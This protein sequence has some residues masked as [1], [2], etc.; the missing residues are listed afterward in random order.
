MV[1]FLSYDKISKQYNLK[2]YGLCDTDKRK[3]LVEKGILEAQVNNQGTFYSVSSIEKYLKKVDEYRKDYFPLMEFIK[4]FTGKKSAVSEYYYYKK[5]KTFSEKTC[6]KLIELDIPITK[7]E[8]YLIKKSSF[9][10]FKNKYLS[11]PQLLKKL[12]KINCYTP[13]LDGLTQYL[14]NHNVEV[15]T[16]INKHKYK[17]VRKRDVEFLLSSIQLKDVQKELNLPKLEYLYTVL[18]QYNIDIFRGFNNISHIEKRD[19]DFLSNL[20]TKLY[21][22]LQLNY[23]TYDEI[24]NL[25]NDINSKTHNF[26]F[27]IKKIPIL[28]RV[29]KYK[30]KTNVY[31]KA[32]V[33]K[34]IEK[35]K[36]EK[37]ASQLCDFAKDSLDYYQL[38]L[39]LLKI[40]NTFFH[41]NIELTKEIWFQY[42][43]FIIQNLNGAHHSN[44]ARITNFRYTTKFLVEFLS[45]KEIYEFKEKQLNIGIFNEN[46]PYQ[47][48]AEIYRF[49][50]K[51]NES[52]EQRGIKIFDLNK[53]SFQSQTFKKRLENE[54][55]SVEE[56]LGL[57]SFTSDYKK[58]KELAIKDLR[59]GISNPNN[60]KKYDSIWLYVLI[61]LN[62]GWRKS[63]VL[64]FPR[65]KDYI[66]SKFNITSID[67][68]ENLQLTYKEA[69]YII[70]SYQIQWYEHNKTKYKATFYCSSLLTIP[71]AYA[72]LICEWRCRVLHTTDEKYLINFYNKRQEIS[73]TGHAAFFYDFSKD[74]KFESRKLNRTVLTLTSSVIKQT[75]N[76]NHKNI[77]DPIKVAGHLRG[78]SFTDTTNKYMK[79]PQE[80]LDFITEQLFDIGYFGF[81]YDY[82]SNTLIGNKSISRENHTKKLQEIKILLGDVVKLENLSIYLK[83]LTQ[84]RDFSY[85]YLNS[86]SKEELENKLKLIKIGLL[87]SNEE[88]YQCLFA[89]CIAN[90]IDCN[91]CPFSIPHFYS[92]TT[93]A[94]RIKRT[95]KTYKT[96]IA[97]KNVPKGEFTKLYNSLIN[98]YIN[99][100]EAEKKFGTEII[101]MFVDDI[102]SNFIGELNLLPD[103]EGF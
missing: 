26:K 28:A 93:I 7:E 88:N 87:S 39:D 103:P 13:T 9:Y 76:S 40:D 44:I 47:Y 4:I 19:F 43:K 8:K 55:Y 54:I 31:K 42:V 2:N 23:Y 50:K 30:N 100:L 95:I 57:I 80:H 97:K 27:T 72:I 48:R 63:D 38:Y 21:N 69:E 82:L 73:K 68:L 10:R 81:I 41:E 25:L 24:V 34:F 12:K 29:K 32:E 56:Y 46:V 67:S 65:P 11:M 33:D 53:I 64:K 90:N 14:K 62:N 92:L 60:Y 79:I 51:F 6:L 18:R 1:K 52:L 77:S 86:L 59:E 74:F 36:K 84:Q 45:E 16:F 49:L 102:K 3:L 89:S 22:E 91:R 96:L 75:F 20:Q 83:Y 37:E 35:I 85:D 99:L 71:L 58:H 94:N 5:V 17:F 98:D 61:H 70:K 15:V 101:E 66:I 78:H